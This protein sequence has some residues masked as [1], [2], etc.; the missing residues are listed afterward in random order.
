MFIPDYDLTQGFPDEW[1]TSSLEQQIAA[2]CYCNFFG[3]DN[4]GAIVNCT[5]GSNTADS[6][7][8]SKYD[9][10]NYLVDSNKISKILFFNLVDDFDEAWQPI[11]EKCYTRLG[12]SNVK[13]I[14]HSPCKNDLN[15]Q[16]W[17]LAANRFFTKY[18]ENDLQLR[19]IKNYFLCYNRK[20]HEH[21]IKLYKR[22]KENN[23]L[24]KGIFTL[25][26]ENHKQS[27]SFEKN[28]YSGMIDA[29]KV[30]PNASYAIPNDLMSLGNMKIWNTSFLNI[31]TETNYQ[32]NGYPF[33][34]EKTFK[35]IIGMRPFLILG[36]NGTVD[37]L[38]DNGFKTF[39]SDFKL[40]EHDLTIGHIVKAI[41]E[42]RIENMHKKLLKKTKH[43][44]NRF[45]EFCLE[46]EKRI[47]IG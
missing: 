14:G 25:G 38:H 18:S 41:K 34:T 1:I 33:L 11:I 29:F 43:N 15:F 8:D 28:G 44:R 6:S 4:D 10:V 20:P 46:E 35:P 26:D 12:E 3:K 21:R 31:V 9:Q 27:I 37:W 45:F 39:N 30:N 5:W 23:L 47:G 16:F 32:T 7:F 40:P 22:L 2:T 13:L 42:T 24:Q 17:P 19:K 36:P